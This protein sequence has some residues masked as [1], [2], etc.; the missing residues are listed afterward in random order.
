MSPCLISQ[1]QVLAKFSTMHH[2][3]VSHLHFLL[4]F[5]LLAFLIYIFIAV[6]WEWCNSF[7]DGLSV[8]SCLCPKQNKISNIFWLGLL[9]TYWTGYINSRLHSIPLQETSDL[10]SRFLT[11]FL[12]NWTICC[13]AQFRTCELPHRDILSSFFFFWVK[14][15]LFLPRPGSS[16]TFSWCAVN[17]DSFFFNLS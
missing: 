8:S 13:S 6:H 7:P 9:T 3:N 4:D 16:S 5:L 10:S 14:I 17:M 15:L 12:S 2:C 1:L 11:P